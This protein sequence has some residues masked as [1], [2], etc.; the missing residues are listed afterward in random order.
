MNIPNKHISQRSTVAIYKHTKDLV[1]LVISHRRSKVTLYS[2]QIQKLLTIS[3]V[4]KDA[5][6]LELKGTPGHNVTQ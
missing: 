6:H 2:V 1:S 3:S 5:E 4:G